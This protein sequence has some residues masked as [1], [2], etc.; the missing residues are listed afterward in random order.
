MLKLRPT[1]LLDCTLVPM[2]AVELQTYPEY[3]DLLPKEEKEC[4]P[5]Q[6]RVAP[7]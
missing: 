6:L 4:T 2:D 7:V 3:Y 5:K 1:V